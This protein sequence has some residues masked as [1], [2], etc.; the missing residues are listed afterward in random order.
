MTW[1]DAVTLSAAEYLWRKDT[2]PESLLRIC[3]Q[4][5]DTF[6]ELHNDKTKR[7]LYLVCYA[8]CQ[9]IIYDC[10]D[11]EDDAVMFRSLKVI[12]KAA[13]NKIKQAS[14]DRW[15][16]K[17][18]GICRTIGEHYGR[19]ASYAIAFALELEVAQCLSHASTACGMERGVRNWTRVKAKESAEQCDII[20]HILGNPFRSPPL[21]VAGN[22]T[23]NEQRWSSSVLNLAQALEAGEDC[24]F[25]MHD[26][27]FDGGY[28]E[29]A[30]HFTEPEHP[31]GCWAVDLILEK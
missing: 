29:L 21:E 22:V 30:E 13:D 31:V 9:R 25:A 12:R 17:V 18:R 4:G 8:A 16:G 1:N 20:R 28:Q 15:H 5:S 7:K 10:L 6:N 19:E 11:E 26:A 23:Y 14:V 24:A 2:D 3:Y 27:L